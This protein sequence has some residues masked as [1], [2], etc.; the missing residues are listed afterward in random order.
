MIRWLLV[1][2]GAALFVTLSVQAGPT[3]AVTD[4][5]IVD[6][7]AGVSRPHQAVL[8][9]NSQIAEI[10]STETVKIPAGT[11]VIDGAGKY[12]MPGLWDMHVHLGDGDGTV[13]A[14]FLTAGVT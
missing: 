9:R 14:L 1:S 11:R 4:V 13:L 2:L 10:G 6:P 3:I 12:L 7:T 8:I 5:A